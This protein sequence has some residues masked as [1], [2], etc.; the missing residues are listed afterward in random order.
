MMDTGRAEEVTS[1]IQRSSALLAAGILCVAAAPSAQSLLHRAARVVPFETLQDT[2]ERGVVTLACEDGAYTRLAELHASGDGVELGLALPGGR[3]LALPL[4]PVSCLA[5]GARARIVQ[6]DG[7]ELWV[8]P[9]AKCFAG[10][11]PG[12]GEVFLGF[13]PGQ[14]HGYVSTGGEQF[15]LSSSGSPPGRATLAH[16]S[17]T[18]TMDLGFCTTSMRGADAGDSTE[19]ALPSRSVLRVA[20]VFVEIDDS[21]PRIFD[22]PDAAIDY[23]AILFTASGEIFR[24][25]VGLALRIPDGYMRLWKGRPPWGW[26]T[27][28]DSVRHWW[29][30]P[31]NPERN[32]PR[33]AVH[34]I[35]RGAGQGVAYIAACCDNTMG[36]LHSTLRGGFPYPIVHTDLANYDLYVVSHEFGHVFGCPHSWLLDPPVHCNDGSGPDMGTLMTYCGVF[37]DTMRFLGMRFHLQEQQ[38]I[39]AVLGRRDC[40]KVAPLLPGDYDADGVR[41]RGDLFVAD[42]ILAQGFRSLGAEETFD[43]DGD[44]VFDAVDREILAQIVAGAEPA[45][46]VPRNGS[47]ANPTCLASLTKPVL[48]RTWSVAVS[49]D[50]LDQPTV[51]VVS[52]QPLAGLATP[53][54]ELLVLLPSMGGRL[55]LTSSV[56]APKGTARHEIPLPLDLSLSQVPL[57]AQAVVFGARGPTHMCNAL[58]LLLSPFE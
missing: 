24:R 3:E 54:G 43:L 44:R 27:T 20:D 11:L 22:S 15:F 21:L 4:R 32:L 49:T 2:G 58:D 8:E 46:A 1:M 48:G 23:A 38:R 14:V 33:A 28:V 25:D 52:D 51:L 40:I 13:A 6:E 34:S 29:N 47:G 37:G 31:S 53:F 56:L 5:P 36:F 18:G 9:R 57:Y 12:G 10:M 39:R 35:A 16:A 17:Q 30:R 41:G 26:N 55:L 7:R 19:A 50:R 42:G 45:R